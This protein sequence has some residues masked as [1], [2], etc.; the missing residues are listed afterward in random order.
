MYY[1]YCYNNILDQ[2]ILRYVIRNI[3]FN[4]YN[5][6]LSTLVLVGNTG[7]R[8]NNCYKLYTRY[9]QIKKK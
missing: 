4:K 5:L 8:Y 2:L 1:F 3:Y 7:K 9:Y 6:K